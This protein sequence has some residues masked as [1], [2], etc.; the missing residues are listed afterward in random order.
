MVTTGS[1]PALARRLAGPVERIA[2]SPAAR[3][4]LTLA[5]VALAAWLI[6]RE[7]EGVSVSQVMSAVGRTR[8]A[9]LLLAVGFT[10]ASYASMAGIEILALRFVGKAVAPLSVV[11]ASATANA[12]SIAMGFGLASGTA[13][14]LRAYDFARLS[15][16]NTA[17]LV[18]TLSA[19][20]FL[21]GMTALGVCTLI[22]PAPLAQALGWTEP[23]VIALAAVLVAG[24]LAAWFALFRNRRPNLDTRQRAL[25]LLASLAGNWLFGGLALFVL[26]PHR[27]ADLTPFLASFLFGGLVGSAIGVPA[28]LG[29]LDASVLSLKSI[30]Q[31]HQTAAALILYRLI[32]QVIPL[33]IAATALG[34]RQMARMVKAR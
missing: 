7:L 13:V 1:G 6:R 12:L 8:P 15:A 5:I 4:G 14:R 9:A 27:L 30:G 32:V 17:K 2:R 21:S 3:A 24:P 16:G 18:L 19:A 11:G 26:S 20:S 34:G 33:A 29:V 31:A 22:S 25:A 28:D 23:L 10:L